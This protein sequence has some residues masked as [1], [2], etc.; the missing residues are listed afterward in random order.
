MV[1]LFFFFALFLL[2]GSMLLAARLD[3]DMSLG[4]GKVEHPPLALLV[5]K[6]LL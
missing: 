3:R 2:T 1:G 5:Q 6:H 4:E